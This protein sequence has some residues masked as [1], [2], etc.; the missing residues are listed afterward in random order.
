MTW[1]SRQDL[2]FEHLPLR[3]DTDYRVLLEHGYGD[4]AGHVDNLDHSWHFR[5]EASPVLV[6]T[7]PGG[8]DGNVDPA[9]V[10]TLNFSR[11]MDA[12]S[13]TGAIA[14]LPGISP[15]MRVDPADPRR[16]L[17]APGALFEP[18]RDYTVTV[19]S[20]ARDLDGN[21]LARGAAVTFSTGPA[22]PLRHRI[23]FI[24][25][26]AGQ[27]ASDGVWMVDETRFPRPLAPGAVYSYAWSPDGTGL[28][29]R[30]PTG[31]WTEQAVAG[32]T[33]ALPLEARWT[34]FVAPGQGYVYLSANDLWQHPAQGA[35]VRLA[36]GVSEATVAPG[37]TRVAYVVEDAGSSQ[38]W[39]YDVGLHSRYRLHSEQGEIS[40]VAWSP[41]AYRLAYLLSTVGSAGRQ[42]RVRSL[43]GSSGSVT[44]ATGMVEAPV[45]QADS[46]HLIFAASV[47]GGD[48]SNISRAYRLAVTA[49]PP[50]RLTLA[51]G[52]PAAGP[53]VL[54]PQPSPDGHQIAFLADQQGNREVFL[55]NADGTGLSQ[56]TSFDPTGFPYSCSDLAWTPA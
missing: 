49:P 53:S 14:V 40:A 50:D 2:V 36:T 25:A 22:Q 5:T 29:I 41:D 6:S 33:T 12:A 24:A 27:A 4:A 23:T 17:V 10:V 26:G 48:G 44:L 52:M 32:T 47:P 20:A 1:E 39:A 21:Q 42:L 28:L 54:Q 16:V 8:G 18:Q 31:A 56:L 13:L 7:S 55:M 51:M 37:G 46:R 9:T 19:T 30:S 3:T 43:T 11:E 15:A 38:I 45:W 34:A 35:D